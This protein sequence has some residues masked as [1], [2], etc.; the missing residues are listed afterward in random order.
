M[1]RKLG[2]AVIWLADW[3]L[4]LFVLAVAVYLVMGL[5]WSVFT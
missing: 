3:A 5:C 1:M 4:S 2:N